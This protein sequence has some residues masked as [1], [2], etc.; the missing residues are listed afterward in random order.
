MVRAASLSTLKDPTNPRCFRRLS[1]AAVFTAA[2]PRRTPTLVAVSPW[3]NRPLSKN[4]HLGSKPKDG[5]YATGSSVSNS[6]NPLAKS[7]RAAV[8]HGFEAAIGLRYVTVAG[9]RPVIFGA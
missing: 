6:A 3:P 2:V 8:T 1:L 4:S 7:K 5:T 9:L